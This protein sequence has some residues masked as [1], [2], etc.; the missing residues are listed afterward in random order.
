MLRRKVLIRG[1]NIVTDDLTVQSMA[2]AGTRL[3][4]GHARL[5]SRP[6]S[7]GIGQD[8]NR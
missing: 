5:E 2:E 8:L 6:G 7:A 1:E 4:A 3:E